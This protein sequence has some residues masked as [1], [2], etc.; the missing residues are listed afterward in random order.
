MARLITSGGEIREH[1]TSDIGCPDGWSAGATATSTSTSVIREAFAS[2]QCDG[3]AANTSFRRWSWTAP[4]LGATLH[5]RSYHQFAALPTSDATIARFRT[6]ADGALV[7]ARLTTAGKL[8]LWN[9]SAGTQI[10]S[11]SALTVSTGTWYRV[12]LSMLINTGAVDTAALYVQQDGYQESDE[13]ISGSSLTVSDTHGA[14]FEAG[15][16][17]NPGATVSCY[18]DDVAVN[19]S[20]GTAQTGLPGDGWVFWDATAT[21]GTLNSWTDCAGGTNPHE[22]L[23]KTPPVGLADHVTAGHTGASAH[24]AR[25]VSNSAVSMG[26]YPHNWAGA[27]VPT[28]WVQRIGASSTLV[29]SGATTPMRAMSFILG[30]PIVATSLTLRLAKGGT[31]TDDLIFEIRTSSA[32]LPTSTVLATAQINGAL[33]TTTLLWYTLPLDVPQELPAG[34]VLWVVA[35]RSGAVSG[36]NFFSWGSSGITTVADSVGGATH[37]GTS[38]AANATTMYGLVV[39]STNGVLIPTVCQTA[40]AHGEATTGTKGGSLSTLVGVTTMTAS[41]NYGDATGVAGTYPTNWRWVKSNV[42]YDQS[43]VGAGPSIT[44]T[45]NSGTGTGSNACLI[46]SAGVMAEFAL[47]SMGWRRWQKVSDSS[48]WWAKFVI[49]ATDFELTGGTVVTV[50]GGDYAIY[51]DPQVDAG[52]DF[53]STLTSIDADTLLGSTYVPA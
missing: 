42:I 11:D 29:G 6:S 41:F 37:N 25:C 48:F 30:T 53:P 49:T 20:T 16:V 51:P 24:Q 23:S 36:T 28:D 17:T 5:A 46:C 2:F 19:D 22:G 45:K 35:R 26:L 34:S 39:V 21:K 43:G 9:D 38:W 32:N 3:T 40:L 1:S 8:Q 4:A 18:V 47:P 12:Q 14:R 15:W 33:L 7:S 31:P 27:G 13:T 10:G 50:Q 52:G 44:M